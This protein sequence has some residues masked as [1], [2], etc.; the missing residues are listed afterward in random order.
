MLST[1][2]KQSRMVIRRRLGRWGLLRSGLA[3][4]AASALI[5][6]CGGDTSNTML[7]G[8]ESHFL[9]QC[10]PVSEASCGP[11]LDCISGVCTRSCLVSEASCGDL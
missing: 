4:L 6:A 8:G 3:T 1:S 5:G 10:T 11:G 2:S 7:L 9:Q